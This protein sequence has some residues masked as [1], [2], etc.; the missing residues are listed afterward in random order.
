MSR[1]ILEKCNFLIEIVL[2]PC[3]KLVPIYGHYL[4]IRVFNLSIEILIGFYVSYLDINCIILLI[5][6]GH[7]REREK[8]RQRERLC[9]CMCA[10]A[11]MPLVVVKGPISS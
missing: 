7:F 6:A 1:N 10:C 5:L 8:Q 9:V 4:E 2:Q 3:T 11:C